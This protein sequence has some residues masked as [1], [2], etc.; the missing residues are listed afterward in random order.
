MVKTIKELKQVSD[1]YLLE[2]YEIVQEHED[3]VR[4]FYCVEYSFGDI[5][6]ELESRGYRRGWTR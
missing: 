1:N 5:V 6:D 3:N 4:D 2:M